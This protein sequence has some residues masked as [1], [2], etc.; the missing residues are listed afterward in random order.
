MKLILRLLIVLVVISLGVVYFMFLDM[1]KVMKISSLNLPYFSYA[2]YDDE[3]DSLLN[4]NIEENSLSHQHF[5][6]NNNF[7]LYTSPKSKK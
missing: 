4:K 2:H 1:S 6:V 3:N 7:H 5:N